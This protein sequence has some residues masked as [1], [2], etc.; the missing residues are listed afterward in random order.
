MYMLCRQS[1][2]YMWHELCAYKHILILNN[3]FLSL[4]FIKYFINESRV[5]IKSLKQKYFTKKFIKL[6]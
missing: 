6:L 1:V 2:D 4:I 5:K 3:F